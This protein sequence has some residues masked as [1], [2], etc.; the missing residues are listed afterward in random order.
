MSFFNENPKSI[1]D[2]IKELL[3]IAV[4]DRH[5]GFHTPIFSNKNQNNSIDSRVIVLRK[6]EKKNLIMNFHTDFRSPKIENLYS[7]IEDNQE[8]QSIYDSIIQFSGWIFIGIILEIGFLNI[9]F[10]AFLKHWKIFESSYKQFYN[11]NELHPVIF[12]VHYI[13]EK[14][15]ISTT[16]LD[17]QC[18][19][20][21]AEFK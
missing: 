5:H 2:N 14:S 11:T 12:L 8:I 10:S 9:P 6:F 19:A 17:E 20:I 7:R 21:Q 1:F 18:K 15:G 16:T 13:L 4:T 3:S